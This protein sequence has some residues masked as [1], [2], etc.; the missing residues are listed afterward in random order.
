MER[1]D[2]EVYKNGPLLRPFMTCVKKIFADN[3]LTPYISSENLLLLTLHRAK[4]DLDHNNL[5]AVVVH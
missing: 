2:K 3:I 4:T 1:S 5:V